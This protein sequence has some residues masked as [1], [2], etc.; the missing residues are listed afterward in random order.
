MQIVT[1]SHFQ[2]HGVPYFKNICILI[3]STKINKLVFSLLLPM[4]FYELKTQR[5]SY[6]ENSNMVIN[7]NVNISTQ[8]FTLILTSTSCA[9]P[10]R[11]GLEYATFSKTF[12][13]WRSVSGGSVSLEDSTKIICVPEMK[14]R[15]TG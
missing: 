15:S 5:D 8:S 3:E 7:K 9:V 6:A 11:E 14:A 4:E 1:E 10:P 12:T 13:I 2:E